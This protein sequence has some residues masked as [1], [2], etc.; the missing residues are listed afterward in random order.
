M[1]MRDSTSRFHSDEVP[2][3]G[4]KRAYPSLWQGNSTAQWGAGSQH[5]FLSSLS[6]GHPHSLP[7]GSLLDLHSNP[8]TQHLRNWAENTQYSGSEWLK[9]PWHLLAVIEYSQTILQKVLCSVAATLLQ[10]ALLWAGHWC[11]TLWK[12]SLPCAQ[13]A[14]HLP[15]CLQM[16]PVSA[17][18]LEA[19]A[20]CDF[21]TCVPQGFKVGTVL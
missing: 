20:L 17:A 18:D 9:F 8:R 6:L 3:W 4:G 7:V 12:P 21:R 5:S 10:R 1:L 16:C 13:L 15:L 19:V 11:E 14:Q 2:T